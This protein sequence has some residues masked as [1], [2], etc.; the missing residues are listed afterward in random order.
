M[1]AQNILLVSAFAYF[2]MAPVL[3]QESDR[4]VQMRIIEN[5]KVISDTT[6][7]VNEKFGRND[8]NRVS[9]MMNDENVLVFRGH[10]HNRS[11][12]YDFRSGEDSIVQGFS[13]NTDSLSTEMVRKFRRDTAVVF[14]DFADRGRIRLDKM[15]SIP[16]QRVIEKEII[17]DGSSFRDHF[18][19]DIFIIQREDPA[20][21][22]IIIKN[23]E[24]DLKTIRKKIDNET[25][26]II[27]KKDRKKIKPER[28]ISRKR[29]R[30]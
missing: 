1:K 14:R 12:S 23:N 19:D 26:I 10:P 9:R 2:S 18:G 7:T 4:K 28:H 17:I 27:I 20:E 22:Q 3:S 5:G 13:F 6:F 30:Y 16:E 21:K 25:E 29:D 11:F 8:I 15:P 24:G